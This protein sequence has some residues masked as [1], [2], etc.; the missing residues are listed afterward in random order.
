MLYD[1]FDLS[2]E[3]VRAGD[4]PFITLFDA[5]LRDGVLAVPEFDSPAVKR[6]GRV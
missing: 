4:G 1:V 5:T 6:P 2:R 3:S